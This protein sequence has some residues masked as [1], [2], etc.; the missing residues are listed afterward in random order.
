LYALCREGG[1]RRSRLLLAT[2]VLAGP[3]VL[4]ASRNSATYR[5]EPTRLDVDLAVSGSGEVA[6]W[7]CW[8]GGLARKPVQVAVPGTTYTHHYW[9]F[10]YEPE[11]HSYAR[12]MAA[13]GYALL[14]YDR[15]GTGESTIPDNFL[16]VTFDVHVE[17]LHRIVQ[18]LRDGSLTGR[19]FDTVT[20]IGHSQGAFIT[21]V[22]AARHGDVD[23][24]ISTGT[25]HT[26]N[27]L[28]GPSARDL[29]W[30]AFL[31]PMW[32]DKAPAGYATSRPGSRAAMFYHEPNADPAVIA[33][34][35]QTKSLASYAELTMAAAMAP[36]AGLEAPVLS[37]VGNRDALFCPFADCSAYAN[38]GLEST[39]WRDTDC[40][41][42]VTLADT[43]HDI[44][45]HRT[46][47]DWFAL[48]EHWL[49]NVLEGRCSTAAA[50][51]GGTRRVSA[52]SGTLEVPQA[53][54]A[55]WPTAPSAQREIGHASRNR[56]SVKPSRSSN[57]TSTGAPMVGRAWPASV[58]ATR[59]PSCSS[60]STTTW[61]TG[62][63]SGS[64]G[65]GGRWV[66][67]WA[68]IVPRPDTGA[69]ATFMVRHRGHSMRGWWIQ[70][71][72]SRQRSMSSW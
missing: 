45:L 46:A 61:R 50:E 38:L 54:G 2:F 56:G 25:L 27:P 68:A 33:L 36:Y 4:A 12:H 62:R 55:A 31:D 14:L 42:L 66:T 7:L 64:V 8:E 13:A 72:Q 3:I 53:S 17:T 22:E 28:V 39:F 70:K 9:D 19:V 58:E 1:I 44:T 43:G 49:A 20:T 60:S 47:R 11:R 35:E 16:D 15:V 23:A 63:S 41:D 24:V 48:A 71:P 10:P 6:A 65:T 32:A 30:P 5:C 59:R 51:P 29:F 52:P 67:A 18:G 40:F 57:T 21:D 69:G 26:V 37:I 34:D